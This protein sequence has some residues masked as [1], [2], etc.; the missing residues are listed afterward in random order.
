MAAKSYQEIQNMITNAPNTTTGEVDWTGD[1][2]IQSILTALNTALLYNGFK[3][4]PDTETLALAG[5]ANAAYATVYKNNVISAYKWFA[6]VDPEVVE[7][8]TS[9]AGGQWRPIF[10][11]TIPSTGPWTVNDDNDIVPKTDYLDS[12]VGI[13]QANCDT[14]LWMDFKSVDSKGKGRGVRL[15]VLSTSQIN[16]KTLVPNEIFYNSNDK[17]H[18]RYDLETENTKSVGVYAAVAS[19]DMSGGT[20]LTVNIPTQH[21]N[22]YLPFLTPISTLAGTTFASGY[23]IVNRLNT[24]FDVQFQTSVTGTIIFGYIIVH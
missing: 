5:I 18:L 16:A 21:V 2:G 7:G 14:G 15:P 23:T 8:I 11:V 24:S 22:T 1:N 3:F 13:G 9:S 12:G 20:S 6:V 19:V 17:M 10:S 4:Y